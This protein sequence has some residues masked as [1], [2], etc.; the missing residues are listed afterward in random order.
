MGL[1]AVVRWGL[2]PSITLGFGQPPL[3]LTVQTSGVPV[4]SQITASC[5]PSG[6]KLGFPQRVIWDKSPWAA[7]SAG[8]LSR[9]VTIRGRWRIVESVA[10]ETDVVRWRG[11]RLDSFYGFSPDFRMVSM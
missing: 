10:S 6:E 5:V 2:A 1:R 3:T 7:A 4:R 11:R 9:Q 8:M